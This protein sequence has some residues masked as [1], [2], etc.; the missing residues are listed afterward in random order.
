MI[1][2]LGLVFKIGSDFLCLL[3]SRFGEHTGLLAADDSLGVIL[4]FSVSSEEQFDGGI[5]FLHMN[6]CLK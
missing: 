6:D 3:L 1:E 2:N 4:R 5:L